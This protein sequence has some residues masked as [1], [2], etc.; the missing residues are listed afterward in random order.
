MNTSSS[1]K[2]LLQNQQVASDEIDQPAYPLD[3]TP[4][5]LDRRHGFL[6]LFISSLSLLNAK[7]VYQGEFQIVL[8]QKNNG[9]VQ[10]HFSPKPYSDYLL[11][12]GPLR[13]FNGNRGTD[14]QQ[15]ISVTASFRS[16]KSP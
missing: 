13:R 14:P 12:W 4:L 1:D 15:L 10:L 6:G 8:E 11:V 5:A 7:P 9:S 3:A 16:R 2:S